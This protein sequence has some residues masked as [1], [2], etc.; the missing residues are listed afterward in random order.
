[1]TGCGRGGQHPAESWAPGLRLSSPGERERHNALKWGSIYCSSVRG[2]VY[3]SSVQGLAEFG[4]LGSIGHIFQPC[5]VYNL[6][7]LFVCLHRH[8]LHLQLF[9]WG[10]SMYSRQMIKRYGANVSSCS[11]PAILSK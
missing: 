11:A 5:P 1:M 2:S 6:W 4:S 8:S 7:H 9:V 3:C 10:I